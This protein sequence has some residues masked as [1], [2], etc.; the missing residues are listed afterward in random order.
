LSD[1]PG[2]IAESSLCL[3]IFGDS[4]KAGRVV[5]H[6]LYECLAMGRP[7]VTR[8]GPAIRSLFSEDEVVTVPPADPRALAGAIRELLDDPDRR[9][10][11][12][13]SGLSSYRARFHEDRLARSLQLG[14]RGALGEGDVSGTR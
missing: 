4:D 13:R 12:A 7:V 5:P 6:K 14:L 8:D 10:R 11:I 3:G 1:L 2:H 9:E